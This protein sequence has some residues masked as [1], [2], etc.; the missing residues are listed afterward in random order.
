MHVNEKPSFTPSG[1][2]A[3]SVSGI[4]EYKF[5]RRMMVW[6]DAREYCRKMYTDLATVYS[7]DENDELQSLLQRMGTDQ[8][9]IGLYDNLS[10]WKWLLDNQVFY[11]GVNYSHWRRSEPNNFN[12]KEKCV[13]ITM[14]GYWIDYQCSAENPSVCYNGKRNSSTDFK[15][16]IGFK[17]SRPKKK[18]TRLS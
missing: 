10:K 13:A 11:N 8:A 5:V 4:R 18:L 17:G 15:L 6:S 2:C 1:L 14:N 12:S 3:A 16:F 9:W 7:R